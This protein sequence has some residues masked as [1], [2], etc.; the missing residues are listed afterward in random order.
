[1]DSIQSADKNGARSNSVNCASGT[2]SK[3][4]DRISSHTP[5]AQAQAQPPKSQLSRSHRKSEAL[6]SKLTGYAREKSRAASESSSRRPNFQSSDQSEDRSP[7][8]YVNPLHGVDQGGSSGVEMKPMRPKYIQQ[9]REGGVVAARSARATVGAPSLHTRVE[10]QRSRANIS[11]AASHR[12]IQGRNIG[13][14]RVDSCS[15]WCIAR[16]VWGCSGQGSVG[17]GLQGTWCRRGC[18]WLQQTGLPCS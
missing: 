15:F 13:A 16:R 6:V 1:M 4:P 5:Q 11:R 12:I 14:A 17:T 18:Q 3:T 7:E 2:E 9:L 8:E 10:I